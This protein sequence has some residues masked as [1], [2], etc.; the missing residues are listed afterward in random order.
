MRNLQQKASAKSIKISSMSRTILRHY[1]RHRDKIS[2][3]CF[4]LFYIYICTYNLLGKFIVKIF[5][6]LE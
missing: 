5:A 3:G 1:G 2:C 4:D 6:C